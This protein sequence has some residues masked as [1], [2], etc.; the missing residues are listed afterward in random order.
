MVGNIERRCHPARS[1]AGWAAASNP[2]T[3]DLGIDFP[4]RQINTFLEGD[5]VEFYARLFADE[6]VDEG[7][8]S[9]REDSMSP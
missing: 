1:R 4:L 5:V 9:S 6:M 2:R 3:R 7:V 8:R